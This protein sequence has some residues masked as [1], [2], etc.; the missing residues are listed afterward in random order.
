MDININFEIGYTQQV[1]DSLGE[2]H[3]VKLS[4]SASVPFPQVGDHVETEFDSGVQSLEVIER[5]F[6]FA[7]NSQRISLIL[8]LPS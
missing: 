6:A 7:A 5:K 3:P 8:D 2:P 1:F 4:Y